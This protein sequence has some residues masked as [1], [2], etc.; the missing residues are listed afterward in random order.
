MA[1]ANMVSRTVTI[2]D[3]ESSNYQQQV[4]HATRDEPTTS[5]QS[6]NEING[7]PLLKLS[8]TPA[9][10]SADTTEILSAAWRR[11]TSTKYIS[12]IKRFTEFCGQ[13][14]IDTCQ[15][16]TSVVL[17]FLT[18]EFK[19]GLKYSALRGTLTAISKVATIENDAILKMFMK[20]AYN[21]RP[22]TPKYHAIWD[23]NRLLGYL[24]K[25]DTSTPMGISRKTTTL[26]MLLLGHRVNTLSHMNITC[27]FLTDTECTFVFDAVLKHSRPGYKQTPMVLRSFPA[28]TQLCPVQTLK[29]YLKFRL[30]KCNDNGLFITTV[31]PHKRSSSDTISRWVKTTLELAGIDSGIFQAHSVRSA[32]T[33]CA[34]R[35]G[36]SLTTIVQ[37]ASWTGT[38]TFKKHYD[39]EINEN[40]VLQSSNEFE[41]A[42]LS[43]YA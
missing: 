11:S 15:A 12:I 43:D 42:I 3:K 35:K 5:S 14:Q 29:Q 32:A 26:F 40:Y 7:S 20:G 16:D 31:S 6:E 36:V 33:S 19:R 9:R 17:E 37:S 30:N 34:K 22:P 4:S 28:N 24:E 1:N 10:V 25:M 21:L 13:K 27:M 39:K 41:T 2:D 18:T 23:T 38:S 8:K